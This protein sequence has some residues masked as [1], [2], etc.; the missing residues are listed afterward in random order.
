MHT[1]SCLCGAVAF[2]VDGDL[3]PPNACHCGQCRKQ[4]G[5]LWASTVTHQDNLNFTA[6]ETLGWY[7]A[8]DIAKRGFCRACGS[9]LFWQ[10]NDEDTIAI[11]VGSLDEPTGLKLAQH[12]F[13]ADKG[14]YYDIKDDLPQRAH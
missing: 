4:S 3:T 14:D 5:H 10:H 9:F 2:V 11:S 6:S 8:S 1:G 7:R 13:V 12:I